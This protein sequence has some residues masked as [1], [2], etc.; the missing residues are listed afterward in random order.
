MVWGNKLGKVMKDKGGIK[1][2]VFESGFPVVFIEVNE[3]NTKIAIATSEPSLS[4]IKL[5]SEICFT[6]KTPALIS[7]MRFTQDDLFILTGL[8]N[9]SIAVYDT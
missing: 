4:L 2:T 7:Y 6:I 1:D 9:G 8:A 3:D 5:D